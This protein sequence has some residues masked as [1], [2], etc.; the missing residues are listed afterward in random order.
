MTYMFEGGDMLRTNLSI[1][2]RLA[3]YHP[4]NLIA[5][6]QKIAAKV[7]EAGKYVV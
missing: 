4:I 7:L 5:I 3:K 6:R 1:A 2:K